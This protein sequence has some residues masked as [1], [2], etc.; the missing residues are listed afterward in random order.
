MRFGETIKKA[1][2]SRFSQASLGEAIGV[3]GTYIGQIEKGE[4][5]PSDERSLLLAEALD[6]DPRKLLIS[7]YK[8]RTQT[9]EAQQLFTQ[10][11]KLMTDPV[12]SQVLEKKFL[13]A[14]TAKALQSPN[15][16]RAL[17][18][19]SWRDA[20]EQGGQMSN[21]NIPELI[22][23]ASKMNPQQLQVLITTAKTFL[24]EI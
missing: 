17:K 13:D 11:E 10:M 23:L 20:L 8:E 14:N 7:A 2:G 1:R 24:G 12:I 22:Q 15:I 21:Q 18:N 19:K 16:R 9:K 6:L 3:W 5:V 4:R